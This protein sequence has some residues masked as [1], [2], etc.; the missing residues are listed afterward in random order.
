[1]TAILKWMTAD[2]ARAFAAG[3]ATW[4]VASFIGI[5]WLPAGVVVLALLAGGPRLALP[6]AAGASLLVL[7]SIVPVFGAV[8][9]GGVIVAVLL[10]AYLAGRALAASR[11][12]T[13]VYQWLTLGAALLVLAIH[14][15][16]GDPVTALMPFVAELDPVLQ[17]LARWLTERGIE[18]TP[19]Q[20]GTE[21]ARVA[22]RFLAWMILANALLALFLGL[23]AFGRLREPG[24]FGREFRRLRLGGFI[25][26]ALAAC[27]VLT[28]VLGRMPGQ[29]FLVTE[30]VVF[31][32]AAAF[33]VQ[34]LAV[35]HGLRELQVIGL[36]PVI[37]AY[38]ALLLLPKAL[39]GI[40]FADTWF[41]FR[42]RFAKR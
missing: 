38:A 42:E 10:P 11:S 3:A 36:V 32:L 9:A 39:V 24:L 27:F 20:I 23:W 2:P 5:A 1:M 29:G 33:L 41:R 37:L 18:T 15:L 30:D 26:W 22:W 7:V 12:L 40:G 13:L 28:I 6:A 17:Q 35:V 16:V 4:A 34:G 8:A 31:V 14:A 19:A 21:A 25:A